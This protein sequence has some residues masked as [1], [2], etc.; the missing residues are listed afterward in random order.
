MTTPEPTYLCKAWGETDLPSAAIVRGVDGI[1]AFLIEEWLGD[2]DAENYAGEKILPAVLSEMQENWEREGQAF[3]W[4]T[5]FEIGGISVQRVDDVG[6][7]K[8]HAPAPTPAASFRAFLEEASLKGNR[9]YIAGPMT[10]LPDFNFPAFNYAAALLRDQDIHVE[11]PAEHGTVDGAEW[12]D[13]LRY[14]LG[15]LA[16]CGAIYLLPGWENSKGAQLEVHVARTL[17]MVLMFAPGA[18]ALQGGA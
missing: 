16:T 4:S 13:Y 1:R 17:G 5:Q 9:A 11:N 14:D 8:A 10:G 12:A 6:A 18:K 7:S 15:R 2:A 3:E